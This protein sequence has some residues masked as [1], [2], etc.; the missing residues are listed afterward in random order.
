[1]VM[2]YAIGNRGM[3]MFGFSNTTK[4]D[5]ELADIINLHLGTFHRVYERQGSE[6]L[7][8]FIKGHTLLTAFDDRDRT[9]TAF[10]FGEEL[11]NFHFMSN[12][13]KE[14]GAPSLIQIMGDG[15]F[16]GFHASVKL[17]DGKMLIHDDPTGS[18]PTRRA[19]ALARILCERHG[20][21]DLS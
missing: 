3:G 6:F 10:T 12:L 1:M 20:A 13:D 5:N 4:A 14:H 8:T 11:S 19:N 21:V 2:L 16:R 15:P 7:I 18:K 17:M 9:F